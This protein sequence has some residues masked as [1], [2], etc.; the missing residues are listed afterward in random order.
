M[1]SLEENINQVNA[2][3]NSIKDAI[4]STGVEVEDGTPTSELSDKIME[5]YNAGGGGASIEI[6]DH[7]ESSD[8]D[9]ALSA[10][11]GRILNEKFADYVKN[12]D[13]E[14][15]FRYIGRNILDCRETINEEANPNYMI[16]TEGD[17][18][19][20]SNGTFKHM[21]SGKRTDFVDISGH[22]GYITVMQYFGSGLPSGRTPRNYNFY[23]ESKTFVSRVVPAGSSN[24]TTG[25]TN[26]VTDLSQCI[27]AV[28]E[29]AKY[30]VVQL[31]ASGSYSALTGI[32]LTNELVEVYEEYINVDASPA[33]LRREI[34]ILKLAAG[35]LWAGKTWVSYGD[36]ITAQGNSSGGY[37]KYVN[38]YKQFATHYGR[39]IGGQKY[40]WNTS[41]FYADEN[42][43]YLG[44]PST[45][46]QPEGSTEHKGAYCSWDRI[47][48][49]IPE[50]VRLSIDLIVLMGGT[51]DHSA[52]E[53]VASDGDVTSGDL[54]WSA[55][56]T[57]DTDWVSD[58]T[59]YN[60]GD[61]DVT[62][63][64]G[65][66]AST[67]MKMQIWCPN[68]LIILAT[69]LGRWNTETNS[70]YTPSGSNVTL[71]DVSEIE[72]EV[73]KY[74][75]IPYIDVNGTTMINAFNYSQYISDGVHPN[76][77]GQKMLAR[78]IINGLNYID[79]LSI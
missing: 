38:E 56:N 16:I 30:V 71:K 10:N 41:T 31:A 27:V 14:T 78:A 60:G 13:Y 34:D 33:T 18:F 20:N 73:A 21:D 52:V 24:T 17:N 29:G 19:V 47:T 63:F 36:S 28:P 42:G 44:R 25:D 68:A 76:T 74:M 11:Q 64:K 55:D 35:N 5:V 39:G 51:N 12:T 4:R 65:A 54:S 58:T 9:K 59:Y 2:D 46:T 23:D 6:I 66:I 37:Q 45:G 1:A 22:N 57:T 69:P 7:L 26:G 43:L 48:T 53:D 15:A 8:T 79:P 67:I 50:S 70:Q 62:T 49:M 75:S 40:I 3:F 72:I 77:A 61:Y 32:Y